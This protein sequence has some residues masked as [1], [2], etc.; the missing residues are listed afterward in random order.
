[1]KEAWSGSEEEL[2]YM[3]FVYLFCKERGSVLFYVWV[4][5]F[6]GSLRA[7]LKGLLSGVVWLL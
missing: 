3:G 2:V 1:M 7:L 6:L 5:V 4:C